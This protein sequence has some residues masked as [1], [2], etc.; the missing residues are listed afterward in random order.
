MIDRSGKKMD[1][2]LKRAYQPASPEDG[3]R[4]LVDRIWPRGVARDSLQIDLWLKEVAPS[5]AL[6]KWFAHDP[7]KWD[8]FQARYRRELQEL[9]AELQVLREHMAQG[10]L[11]LVYG[12]KDKTHNQAVVLRDFLLEG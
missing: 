5:T 3:Y 8:E 6:R 9:E 4:V 2:R 11:T 12:A 1:V 10:V 7:A